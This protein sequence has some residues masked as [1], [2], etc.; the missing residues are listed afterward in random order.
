MAKRIFDR[1][2]HDRLIQFLWT[3]LRSLNPESYHQ[4]C[5]RTLFKSS[6]YLANIVV[7]SVMLMAFLVAFNLAGFHN[8]LKTE[9]QKVEDINLTRD[10]TEP[11]Y[12]ESQGIRV[13]DEANYTGE[14]LLITDNEI[15]HKPFLCALIKPACI[16]FNKPKA[17]EY[18]DN[19]DDLANM[20]FF[21]MLLLIPG[22][23]CL[24][25]IYFM[26]KTALIILVVSYAAKLL[27]RAFKFRVAFIKIIHIAIYASTI[28]ILLE[29]INLIV[30]NLYYIH[31]LVFLI[32]FTIA[33]LLVGEHKHKYH[34]I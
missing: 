30:W 22:M 21:F 26:V 33:V 2:P 14:N 19:P 27:A 3:I 28:F 10:M 9:L 34:N 6:K 24:Y 29:P 25:L 15:V 7:M 20:L 18:S 16:I 23:L 32:I 11:I 12:F 1:D 8:A 13:A 4:L 17:I 5:Q 31:L